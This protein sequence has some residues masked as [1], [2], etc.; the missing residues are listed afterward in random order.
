[1]QRVVFL[2]AVN[3]GGTNRCRPAAI[4]KKL[5]DFKVVNVGAVGTFV[6]REDVTEAV[7]RGM[8]AKELPFKCEIMIC[9]AREVLALAKQNP[10][11]AI[12][13]DPTLTAFVS[14]ASKPLPGRLTLPLC[15]PS[16]DEWLVKVIAFEGRLMAGTYRRHMKAIGYL[17][18]L[19]KLIGVPLTTRSWD[20]IQKVVD[21]LEQ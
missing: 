10:F 7:L 21:A 15:L 20:T 18:K 19:E 12:D 14:I 5:S 8:L 17:G 16:P 4:A 9:T 3:V 2:R 13:N 11:A 6:V 1:M